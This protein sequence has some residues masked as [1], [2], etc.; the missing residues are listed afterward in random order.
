MYT[1]MSFIDIWCVGMMEGAKDQLKW[2]QLYKPSQHQVAPAIQCQQPNLTLARFSKWI[3]FQIF[4]P[5][6]DLGQ[7]DIC[8]NLCLTLHTQHHWHRFEVDAASQGG[9]LQDAVISVWLHGGQR[10]RRPKK[11][12]TKM[13]KQ[14][15]FCDRSYESICWHNI[16]L[17]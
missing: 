2:I 11:K 4:F 17:K 3:W 14:Q 1:H 15:H 5:V 10:C 7:V 6:T 12:Q 16:F 9:K 13:V 8:I